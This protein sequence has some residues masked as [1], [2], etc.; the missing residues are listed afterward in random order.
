MKGI[1]VIERSSVIRCILEHLE[2]LEEEKPQPPTESHKMV[3][4]PFY[5]QISV[6][7]R[8]NVFE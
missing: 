2:F 3:C 4:K 7:W 6:P 5:S 1:P 8:N